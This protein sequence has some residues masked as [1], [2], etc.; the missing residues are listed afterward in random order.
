MLRS[1]LLSLSVALL[2]SAPFAAAD[3]E[4]TVE[5]EPQHQTNPVE[6]ARIVIGAQEVQC[7]LWMPRRQRQPIVPVAAGEDW[8]RSMVVY[9]SNRSDQTIVFA[10]LLLSFPETGDGSQSAP[11][12]TEH[13]QLGRIPPNVTSLDKQGKPVV[14]PPAAAL[15]FAPGEALAVKIGD[16]LQDTNT[17]DAPTP[18]SQLSKCLIAKGTFFFANGMRWAGWSGFS[19]P[20]P[21]QPAK[22]KKLPDDYFPGDPSANWPP[23]VPR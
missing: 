3:G 23:S 16:Y 7:G 22:F 18:L 10:Q 13:I 8:L 1:R 12:R 20:D 15:A 17:S 4:K 5:V 2:T 6:V 11:I 9:L 19:V 14:Q 21:M